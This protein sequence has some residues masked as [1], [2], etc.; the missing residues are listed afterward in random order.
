MLTADADRRAAIDGST[1]IAGDN[2]SAIE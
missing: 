2:V 1:N